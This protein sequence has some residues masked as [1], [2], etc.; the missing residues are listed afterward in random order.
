MLATAS[1]QRA[2]KIASEMAGRA[3]SCGKG[4]S[5]HWRNAA[6]RSSR[7]APER[8]LR[9]GTRRGGYTLFSSS[10]MQRQCAVTATVI[11]P[12]LCDPNEVLSGLARSSGQHIPR[13]ATRPLREN[14]PFSYVDVCQRTRARFFSNLC[15]RC[16]RATQNLP[17][18]RL[19]R[20]IA[21]PTCHGRGGLRKSPHRDDVQSSAARPVLRSIGDDADV[22]A[23]SAA[24]SIRHG[25]RPGRSA[26]RGWV[27][28][29]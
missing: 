29:S 14:S 8:S 6:A 20:L 10:A 15:R 26:F 13:R 16:R 17:G 25:S 21:D 18:R 5:W 3:R 11:H 22:A 19:D 9:C 27:I 24:L 12:R 7:G 1:I 2:S 4:S 23:L 28:D